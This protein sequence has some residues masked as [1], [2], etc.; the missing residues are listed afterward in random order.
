MAGGSVNHIGIATPSLDKSMELWS[1]LGFIPSADKIS[2]DQGVKIRYLHGTGNTRIELLEPLSTETPV[3]RFIELRGPGVQQIAIDVD[4]IE[5]MIS[6]LVSIGVR[7][8]SEVPV[9]GSDGHRIAFV[10]P[11]SAGGVLIE[12]V[13]SPK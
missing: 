3:G 12:L 7:M 11:S 2:E 4:N 10:H 8:V 1:K 9:I 6:D 13:E 5:S